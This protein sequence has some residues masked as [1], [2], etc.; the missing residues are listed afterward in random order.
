MSNFIYVLL[1][2]SGL[3]LLLSVITKYIHGVP[4]AAG[5][6]AGVGPSGYI[7]ATVVL[8]LICANLALLELLKKSK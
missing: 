5:M 2:F 7:I 4:Q 8:L 3:T 1:G 6:V